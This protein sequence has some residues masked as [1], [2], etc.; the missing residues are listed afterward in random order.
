VLCSP[1]TRTEVCCRVQRFGLQLSHARSG[2]PTRCRRSVAADAV[3]MSRLENAARK[4]LRRPVRTVRGRVAGL[5]TE[6]RR[7]RRPTN[8][9]RAK[10]SGVRTS[11][12]LIALIRS[13]AHTDKP[14]VSESLCSVQQDCGETFALGLR[15]FRATHGGAGRLKTLGGGGGTPVETPIRRRTT[16]STTVAFPPNGRRGR[17]YSG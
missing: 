17:G 8:T 16:A 12:D 5:Q 4:C 11:F 6:G 3:S 7:T 13:S 9:A 14:P 1:F 10:R 2:R 15:R